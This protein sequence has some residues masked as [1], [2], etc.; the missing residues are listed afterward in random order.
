MNNEFDGS[1]YSPMAIVPAGPKNYEGLT[2]IH[3]NYFG[4]GQN[5]PY[6]DTTAMQ[7]LEMQ[8]AMLQTRMLLEEQRK[9]QALLGNSMR[10][11]GE[12]HLNTVGIEDNGK[13]KNS[14]R[15]TDM[16]DAIDGVYEIVEDDKE[17]LIEEEK[18]MSGIEQSERLTVIRESISQQIKSDKEPPFFVEGK[19]TGLVEN[20]EIFAPVIFTIRNNLWRPRVRHIIKEYYHDKNTGFL[21]KAPNQ[22]NNDGVIVILYSSKMEPIEI[23]VISRVSLLTYTGDDEV[24]ARYHAKDNNMLGFNKLI[25]TTVKSFG[26]GLKNY[27]HLYEPTID[28]SDIPQVLMAQQSKDSFK[29]DIMTFI[30]VLSFAKKEQSVILETYNRAIFRGNVKEY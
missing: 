19:V 2:I 22:S 29:A 18:N 21:K 13:I 16:R 4:N 25:N 7:M 6:Q 24:F 11:I 20:S 8:N 10:A 14:N 27:H 12:A 23:I 30:P 3:H 9:V 1:M 15:L 26:I 28:S 17:K 5:N